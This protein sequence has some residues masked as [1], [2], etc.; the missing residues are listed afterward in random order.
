MTT[1]GTLRNVPEPE[2]DDIWMTQFVS[3]IDEA[4][5]IQNDMGGAWTLDPLKRLGEWI[6]KARTFATSVEA[7]SVTVG[8]SIGVAPSMSI[9]VTFRG[10]R[11]NIE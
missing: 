2:R 11:K 4:H 9:A 1:Y 7:G 3:L 5:T 6:E 8:V 10:T